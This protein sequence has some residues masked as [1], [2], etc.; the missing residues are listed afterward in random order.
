MKWSLLALI[1]GIILFCNKEKKNPI[2]SFKK[3][4]DFELVGL[5]GRRYSLK[6]NYGKVVIVD[7]WATWCTPCRRV[8]SI[9]NELYEKYK[10]KNLIILGIGLDNEM[11][12]R[13]FV[14]EQKILYPTVIGTQEIAIKYGVKAIPT[15]FIIDKKGKIVSKFVGILPGFKERIE[16]EIL[17]LL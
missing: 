12:L 1:G 3:A 8:M 13:K 6:E 2:D 7:F 17:K 5:D 9:F 11:S 14:E 10:K 15:I 4:P 16:E